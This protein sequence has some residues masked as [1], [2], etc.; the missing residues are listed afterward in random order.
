[1]GQVDFWI[2]IF[3]KKGVVSL[4]DVEFLRG[5]GTV[6]FVWIVPLFGRN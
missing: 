5:V 4:F 6:F 3:F 2:G 1:M